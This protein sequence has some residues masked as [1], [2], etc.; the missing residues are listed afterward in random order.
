MN[1]GEHQSMKPI[2]Q[3]Q[4]MIQSSNLILVQSCYVMLIMRGETEAK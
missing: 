4:L 3:E 1:N 2:A